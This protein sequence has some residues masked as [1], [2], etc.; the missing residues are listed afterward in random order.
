MEQ[1]YICIV[2]GHTLTVEEYNAMPEDYTCP[3]C[4]VGKEDY[5]LIELV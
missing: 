2:C 3:D 4:G 1:T 5:V